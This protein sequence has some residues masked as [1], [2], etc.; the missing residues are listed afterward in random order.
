V[1]RRKDNSNEIREAIVAAT[2]LGRVIRTFPNNL[3]SIILQR[4]IIH[5]VKTIKTVAIPRSEHPSK[6]TPRSDRAMWKTQEQQLRL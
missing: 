6:C 4:K 5:M 1:P 3:K 2:N